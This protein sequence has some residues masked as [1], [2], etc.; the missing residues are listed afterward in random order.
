MDFMLVLSGLMTTA[1]FLVPMAPAASLKPQ[2]M[3]KRGVVAAGHP[4]V[5]E[6]GFRMLQKGGNAVDAGIASVFAAGVV[7]QMSFGL[8]GEAPIL[9]KLKGK[10]VVAINGS[11]WAPALATADFYRKLPASDPRR[12]DWSHVRP[13]ARPHP[14]VWPVERNRPR[15]Y[16]RLAARVA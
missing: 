1:V 12:I 14:L 4:L 2:V 6:A 15:R 8:G 11:G 5:A 16:R 10:P 7:E 9:I 3:G 13:Q